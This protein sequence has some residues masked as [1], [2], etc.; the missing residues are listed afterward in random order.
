MD[1]AVGKYCIA[2]G[3]DV[4]IISAIIAPMSLGT[5]KGGDYHVCEKCL[6]PVLW[7]AIDRAITERRRKG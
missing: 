4:G 3:K 1:C 2:C 7:S 6:G 5:I